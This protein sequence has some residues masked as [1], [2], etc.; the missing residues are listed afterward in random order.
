MKLQDMYP[1][2]L[3]LVLI[4][5]LIGVGLTVLGNLT[6]SSSITA[7][8]SGAIN[9]SIT[10]IGGFSSWFSIIV[11]VLVAAIIIGLVIH[12]FSGR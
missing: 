1:S 10:A 12:S 11:V 9:Q 7:A 6:T 3:T 5:I 4:A 2:V 8:G